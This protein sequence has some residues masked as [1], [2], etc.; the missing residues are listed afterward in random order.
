MSEKMT[1]LIEAND[2]KEDIVFPLLKTTI[3]LYNDIHISESNN[4]QYDLI[5]TNKQR[6]KSVE[7]SLNKIQFKPITISF[8]NI[9]YIIGNETIKNKQCLH[10]QTELFPFWKSIPTKQILSDVSGI[11]TP[12]MNAILGIS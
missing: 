8:Y 6:N 11:F 5:D 4:Y 1:T 10:W 2:E 3:P 9:N 12:G 7:I